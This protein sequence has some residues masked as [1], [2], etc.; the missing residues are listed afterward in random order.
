MT[1][2]AMLVEET[3]LSTKNIRTSLEKLK[4]TGDVAI[5][6]ANAYSL[7]TIVNYS[8]YQDSNDCN[9]KQSGELSA[10]EGQTTGKRGASNL[11]DVTKAPQG[12][13]LL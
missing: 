11:F 12:G 7:V 13:T 8:D 3:G 6:A 4:R 5:E 10:N 1:S 2:V 9:G